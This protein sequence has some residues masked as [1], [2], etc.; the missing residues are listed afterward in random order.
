MGRKLIMVSSITYAIKGR[1][2]LKR[3]GYNAY[4]EKTP[5][6]LDSA[7]C[8]YSIFINGD[9]NRAEEILNSSGIKLNGHFEGGVI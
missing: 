8:G 5:A 9:L 7:G 4:I 1:D 6:G 3:H 2:I